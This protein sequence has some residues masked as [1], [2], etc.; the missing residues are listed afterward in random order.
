[1]ARPADSA[2]VLLSVR[3]PNP[4]VLLVE[5][6]GVQARSAAAKAELK[7]LKPQDDPHDALRH[8]DLAR[9]MIALEQ[10]EKDLAREVT[11]AT[12]RRSAFL[13]V[14]QRF[15]TAGED[16]RNRLSALIDEPPADDAERVAALRQLDTVSRLLTRLAFALQRVSSDAQF[17]EPPSALRLLKN[18]YEMRILEIDQLNVPGG[19]QRFETPP[20]LAALLDAMEGRAP[21]RRAS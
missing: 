1:M 16:F 15:K 18:E 12:E 11:A 5:L 3:I 14:Y 21:V 13:L 19:K 17:R 20:D 2:T 7:G 10:Q 9:E 6:R 4:D 8:P